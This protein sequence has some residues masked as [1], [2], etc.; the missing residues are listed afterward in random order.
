MY[1]FYC[2]IEPNN[3][4]VKLVPVLFYSI[5]K[6]YI[7]FVKLILVL[8]VHDMHLANQTLYYMITLAV[9]SISTFVTHTI[10]TYKK[11]K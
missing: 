1:V 6:Q 5:M 4:E 7:C 2:Q 10:S 3:Y 8:R 11:L 9:L